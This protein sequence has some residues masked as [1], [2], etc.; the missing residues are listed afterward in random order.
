MM[1]ENDLKNSTGSQW[2]GRFPENQII[3]L[4]QVNRRL[5]LAESTSQDL[6]FG[7]L[8]D[9]VG[10]DNVKDI[11]LGYSSAQ[12]SEILCNEVA[13]MCGV[14]SDQV[15]STQGTALALYLLAVEL[16]RPG[17]EAL[18]FTP[19][20]PPSR[21]SLVG[22]G[23]TLNE[24]PLKFEDGYQVHLIEFEARLTKKTKLVNLATPQNPS[25][26][27][28]DHDTVLR[29][30]DIMAI[31]APDAY[32][33]ID[34]TYANATYGNNQPAASFAALHPRI[35]TGSSV[36]KAYGAPGLRVGWM[37]TP[38]QDLRLRLMTAKMNIVISGSPLNETLAA[39]ILRNRDTVLGT[40]RAM[41]S[42]ALE[43]VAEWQSRNASRVS[44]VRPDGGAL[45]CF[46]LEKRAF[47][48]ERV[49]AFWRKLPKLDLQLASG[50]WFGE[51]NRVFRLGFG[52]LPVETL[53]E[54]LQTLES[55]LIS[56]ASPS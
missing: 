54:A 55:V 17:D 14:R 18:I 34:E 20:F 27:A 2:K 25:G 44:W 43:L 31:A 5:N 3:S 29:M 6:H 47:N 53:K 8:L 9:L 24:V 15:V 42:Q 37:T 46:R 56:E 23:I 50:E 36:T 38:D 41:L 40:R 13:S 26:V 51:T 7:E 48:N 22:S 49:D 45:C 21:D 11:R 1:N 4:L 19:C 33:F 39:L 10:Y 52:Y 28:T 32:L 16:C 30:L 35:I 12:G